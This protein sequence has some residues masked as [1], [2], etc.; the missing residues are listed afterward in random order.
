[1]GERASKL[2]AFN[3]MG[4]YFEL[5]ISWDG[6]FVGYP[7]YAGVCAATVRSSLDTP[8][9][10]FAGCC[11][12]FQHAYLEEEHAERRVTTVPLLH[13]SIADLS[14]WMR[15]LESVESI[16]LRK[17]SP[18][19]LRLRSVNAAPSPFSSFFLFWGEQ[20]W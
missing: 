19:I 14:R 17:D 3:N 4:L 1:M 8:G 5:D 12:R 16:G 13:R 11:S 15:K 10:H 18:C 7:T 2:Y 20:A 9:C 6:I